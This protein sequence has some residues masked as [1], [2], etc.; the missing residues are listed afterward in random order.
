[1]SFSLNDLSKKFRLLDGDNE[2]FF[3]SLDAADLD[4]KRKTLISFFLINYGLTGTS[5]SDADLIDKLN[6]NE[7]G[8]L[9]S[10]IR[11]EDDRLKII[12][13]YA[14]IIFLHVQR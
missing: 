13:K 12:N 8:D 14:Q 2:T 9:Y 4:R 5:I 11:D 6:R 7:C 10:N 3:A 1:M